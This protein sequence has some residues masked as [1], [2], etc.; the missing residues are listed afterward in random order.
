MELLDF[1]DCTGFVPFGG[2]VAGLVL[3]TYP[4]TNLEWGEGSCMLRPAVLREA[5]ALTKCQL[6]QR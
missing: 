2:V 5:V 3:D 4:I 6:S 1:H